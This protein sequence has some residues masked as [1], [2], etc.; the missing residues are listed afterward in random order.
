MKF[1]I[2]VI[3][4][5]AAMF[6]AG[7][8]MGIIDVPGLSPAQ[9]KKNAAALY[10]EEGE[11]PADAVKEPETQVA[12]RPAEQDAPPAKPEPQKPQ[13]DPL[14]GQRE[15][16]KVWRSVDADTISAMVVS[17]TDD[18][19]ARQFSVMPDKQ[20]GEI[21]ALLPADRAAKLCKLIQN[22][23]QKEAESNPEQTLGE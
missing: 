20:V 16:A 12:S 18:E 9:K 23:A 17:W 3:V 2:I 14:T 13:V 10:T 7:A 1:L 15:L 5:L 6:F 8:K 21:I 22:L 11:K 19:L 4:A